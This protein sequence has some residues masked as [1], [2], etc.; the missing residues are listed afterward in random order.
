MLRKLR[1]LPSRMSARGEAAVDRTLEFGERAVDVYVDLF[2]HGWRRK[3][4]G[5]LLA[6]LAA[7]VYGIGFLAFQVVGWTVMIVY[8]V[9]WLAIV[10]VVCSIPTLAI[11]GVLWA[12]GLTAGSSSGGGASA[13]FCD[14]HDCIP[15][16]DEGSGSVVQCADGSWSQSG[17]RSGACS[18]HGGEG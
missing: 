6:P 3:L 2:R 13:S 17:G 18:H 7:I 8:L 10:A 4:L 11:W 15:N 16:F 1:T 12:L 14:T 5:V 9:V